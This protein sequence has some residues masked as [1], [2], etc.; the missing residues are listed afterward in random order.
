M[1]STGICGRVNFINSRRWTSR[2][3]KWSGYWW[4]LIL[5]IL[6]VLQTKTKEIWKQISNF[7][8]NCSFHCCFNCNC[9][10]FVFHV[11]VR[12]S[13][14]V[15]WCWCMCVQVDVYIC[16]CFVVCLLF[17]FC[18]FSSV[19]FVVYCSL[20]VVRC[21]L[22]VNFVCFCCLFLFLNWIQKFIQFRK[23]IQIHFKIQFKQYWNS[24]TMRK[25]T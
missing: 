4:L 11:C 24:K 2:R 15:L 14:V 25:Q 22:F 18:L 9:N 17:W 1:R 21:S 12:S 8:F 7:N 13:C 23:T 20:F 6:L 3:V 10:Y 16:I 19:H 5:L